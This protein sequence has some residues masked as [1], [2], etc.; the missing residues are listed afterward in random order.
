M[1]PEKS[2]LLQL[3]DKIPFFDEFSE[4]EKC[5]LVDKSGMVKKYEK[6]DSIIFSEGDKGG[7][8]LVVLAGEV[9]IIK[10]SV[11]DVGEGRLSLRNPKE[12]TLAKLGVG[13]VIGEVSLLNNRRR[14]TGVI[15]SVPLLIVLEINRKNLESFNS[16]I[17]SKFH[18]KFVSILINRLEDMNK[19]YGDLKTQLSKRK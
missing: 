9:S 7:S 2:P 13:S 12:I 15:S 18:K 1:E 4:S 17:Q 19:K 3:I 5:E 6:K 8:V 10:S 14:T 11:P 16:S